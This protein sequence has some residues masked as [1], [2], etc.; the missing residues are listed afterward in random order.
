VSRDGITRRDLLRGRT[1]NSQPPGHTGPIVKDGACLPDVISWLDP[2]MGATPR[3]GSDAAALALLRPPGAIAE[4]DFLESCTKCG[5]CTSACPHD[6]IREAPARLREARGTPIIDPLTSPCRMCEDLPCI[7]ACDTGALRPEAPA[8]LG[9]AQIAPL[10][11]LNQL[12]TTC[13]VCVEHCP[14]PG[15]IEIV[16]I[17]PEVNEPLCT[18]CGACQHVCPAPQNAILLLPNTHRPTARALDIAHA[19]GAKIELPELREA[20]LDEAGLRALFRDLAAATQIDEV[21]CKRRPEERAEP[22][23]TSPEDALSWLLEERVR[24]VQIRY[25]YEGEAWVDTIL[26][27]TRGY[28][29]VRLAAVLPTSSI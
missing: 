27:T 6:A 2:K 1:R 17:V 13:S 14:V 24:G 22:P 18:G 4:A 28:R 9:A 26:A 16:G 20:D 19:Q 5:D 3:R 21:R 25:R 10:D 23:Q 8:A 29:I 7:T 15:A 11:C 12:S